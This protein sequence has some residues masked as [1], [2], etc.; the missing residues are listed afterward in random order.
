MGGSPVAIPEDRSG[1]PGMSRLVYAAFLNN[2][3]RDGISAHKTLFKR[4]GAAGLPDNSKLH[5]LR[6]LSIR[7]LNLRISNL[8]IKLQKFKSRKFKLQK[9]KAQKLK[10]QELTGTQDEI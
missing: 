6:N 5:F 1:L 7:N 4:G 3:R 10:S 2:A 9:L 8:R